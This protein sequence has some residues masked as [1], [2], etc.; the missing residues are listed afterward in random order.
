MIYPYSCIYKKHRKFLAW[1]GREVGGDVFRKDINDGCL[2]VCASISDLKEK[3]G[4]E[5]EPKFCEE[6]SEIS[7]DEFWVS[8]KNL[9]TGRASSIKTYKILLDGW[10]FIEDLIR[11][12]GQESDLLRLRCPV[13]DKLYEKL[14]WGNNLPAVTPE[15]ASY[16]PIWMQEEIIIFRRE[17]RKVWDEFFPKHYYQPCR[18]E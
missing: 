7:F 10:N 3:L 15:G 6:V 18:A 8:V 16:S 13:L 2:L 9:R 1:E 14:F 12:V 11:T 4:E 5:C 17:I